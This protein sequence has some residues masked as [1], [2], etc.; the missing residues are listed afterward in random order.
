MSVPGSQ[1]YFVP[2]TI[3]VA[4]LLLLAS[5]AALPAPAGASPPAQTA[6]KCVGIGSAKADPSTVR[7]DPVDLEVVGEPLCES[8]RNG[9]R[10]V[11]VTRKVATDARWQDAEAKAVV[12]GV[13]AI[14]RGD[15]QAAVVTYDPSSARTAQRMTA[16]LNKVKSSLRSTSVDN[17]PDANYMAENAAREAVKLLACDD[18]A[19]CPCRLVVFFGQD[20]P[21]PT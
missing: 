14:Y 17:P 13:A 7:C 16:D 15:F 21:T 5:L 1:R 4:A 19:T 10:L 6:G 18:D 20:P 8:C 11:I 2:G 9:L 12:D 3:A